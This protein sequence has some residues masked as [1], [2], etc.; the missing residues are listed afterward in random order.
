MTNDNNNDN[1]Q[2][3]SMFNFLFSSQRIEKARKEYE[4]ELNNSDLKT[5]TEHELNLINSYFVNYATMQLLKLYAVNAYNDKADY[6]LEEFVN[7]FITNMKH[8]ILGKMEIDEMTGADAHLEQAFGPDLIAKER[9]IIRERTNNLFT[10]FQKQ[11][12]DLLD[13]KKPTKSDD[14]NLDIF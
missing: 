10:E 9:N 4:K 2:M 11:M 6:F 8:S 3:D 1:E 13:I 12:F 5:P 7:L 14:T